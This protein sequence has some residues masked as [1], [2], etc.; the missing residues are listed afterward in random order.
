MSDFCVSDFCVSD[1]CVSDFCVCVVRFSELGLFR[2]SVAVSG[3]IGG[4][5]PFR[6]TVI[7]FLQTFHHSMRGER[8]SKRMIVAD[9]V[10]ADGTG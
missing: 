4:P 7:R 1:F 10:V 9:Q 6:V 5:L 2:G 8:G 3:Y